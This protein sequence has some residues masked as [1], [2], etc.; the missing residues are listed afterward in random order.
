MANL[1]ETVAAG[2][3]TNRPAADPKDVVRL[4]E[5][6]TDI[7]A[8]PTASDGPTSIAAATHDPVTTLDSGSVAFG[9]SG[10][11]V[12]AAVR[13]KASGALLEDADGVSVDIGTGSTQAAA[14]D[15]VHSDEHAIATG[16]STSS[17]T[18][19]VGSDQIVYVDVRRER[20]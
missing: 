17:A 4:A 18:S 8:R 20:K 1:K 6:Q 12:T 16:A 10:Q 15:H 11:Q 19:T 3:K 7:A 13:L 14:G 2:L 9:L 5:H